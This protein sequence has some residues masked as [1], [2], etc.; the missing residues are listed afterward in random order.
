MKELSKNIFR[1]AFPTLLIAPQLSCQTPYVEPAGGER[2]SIEF[3]NESS[4]P[5]SQMVYRGAAEC[6]DRQKIGELLR[7]GERR[8]TNVPTGAA[9]VEVS[10]DFSRMYT[11]YGT[12][13]SGCIIPISFQANKAKKY[14]LTFRQT[15]NA[16][17]FD[18]TEVTSDGRTNSTAYE[19]RE[20]IKPFSESGPFC[21]PKRAK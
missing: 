3:V 2:A 10:A 17:S 15:D 1:L 16:C 19:Q 18:F 7:P 8:I 5:M 20:W 12:F 9:A 6:T 11:Q 14:R 21:R 13:A 4:L